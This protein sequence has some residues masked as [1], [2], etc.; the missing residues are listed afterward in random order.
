[1]WGVNL[2]KTGVNLTSNRYILLLKKYWWYN[3]RIKEDVGISTELT[4][5]IPAH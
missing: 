5:A 3:F 2:T 1:V 4:E